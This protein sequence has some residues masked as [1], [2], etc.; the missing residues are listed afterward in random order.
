MQPAALWIATL[1]LAWA[2]AC[3]CGVSGVGICRPGNWTCTATEQA[4]CE[5]S[6][7]PREF[8]IPGNG[9]DD[10]CNGL[11]DESWVWP[12]G[13][14]ETVVDC[15]VSV[16]SCVQ[17]L[18]EDGRCQY[19]FLA[20]GTPCKPSEPCWRKP[21]CDHRGACL[22]NHIQPDCR[23]P[24]RQVPEQQQEQQEQQQSSGEALEE[25]DQHQA[26]HQVEEQMFDLRRDTGTSTT[27]GTG[28]GESDPSSSSSGSSSDPDPP[29][30]GVSLA[31][32]LGS[33]L[34]AV[35]LLLLIAVAMVICTN[36]AQ[37]AR[38]K[39]V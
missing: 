14:C 5:G 3:P 33:V 17:A 25:E 30:G 11:V 10:D 28:T 26:P 31:A 1:F 12:D 36:R 19:R 15:Q 18:C 16:S 21:K 20:A 35:C 4:S 34:P 23:L 24:V 2:R 6:V 38:M 37:R 13:I 7:Y 9:L 32:L 29:G 39:R 22:G 8:E 27:A